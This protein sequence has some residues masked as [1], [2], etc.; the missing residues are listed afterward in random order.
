[1]CGRL[2]P[3]LSIS[4]PRAQREIPAN[5]G[6]TIGG[7]RRLGIIASH[8]LK[9]REMQTN[10]T[11]FGFRA[12]LLAVLTAGIAMAAPTTPCAHA[13]EE[14]AGLQST[15]SK[16]L[17]PSKHSVADASQRLKG[18]KLKQGANVVHR[19]PNGV[20]V[21]AVV[22]GTK[23]TRWIVANKKG[24]T[25]PSTAHK[26]EEGSCWVCWDDNGKVDCIRIP[27]DDFDKLP[28][29]EESKIR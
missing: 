17:D 4:L 2:S 21:S 19:Q 16:V 27:C 15:K 12:L 3:F 24:R 28:V 22:K 1:V 20:K 10:L 13:G 7:R 5:L 29:A 6:S 14:A 23:V 18:M 8:R 26:V 9:E 11:T 25:I